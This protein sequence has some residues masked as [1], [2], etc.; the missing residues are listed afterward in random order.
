[1]HGTADWL[2]KPMVRT[3]PQAVTII[4]PNLQTGDGGRERTHSLP[5]AHANTCPTPRQCD[6]RHATTSTQ[7]AQFE[8]RPST[9][10]PTQ[11][12]KVTVKD[13]GG[14][15]G[16][17]WSLGQE[18]SPG[19]GMAIHSSTLATERGAWCALQSIGSQRT[20]H[21]RMT[22]TC[23]LLP[24]LPL[25]PLRKLYFPLN[26]EMSV[27]ITAFHRCKNNPRGGQ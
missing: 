7:T 16:T 18:E 8:M 2:P 19:E 9:P 12:M 5:K 3:T 4:T 24:M 25:A 22:N 15:E 6:L 10:L 11:T 26:P 21:D 23:A 14:S 20:G 13:P 1:M 17:E 27:I